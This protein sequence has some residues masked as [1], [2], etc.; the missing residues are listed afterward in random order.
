MLWLHPDG[1]VIFFSAMVLYFLW[2]DGHQLGKNFYWAAVFCGVLTSTKLVGL[3][4][5]LAVLLCLIWYLNKNQGNWKQ[6]FKAGSLFIGLMLLC[7]LFANAFLFSKYGRIQYFY[8][9]QGQT[10]WLSEGYGVI[11]AKGLKAAL[12][13]LRQDYGSA[14]FIAL[15][16]ALT[17]FGI[18]QEHGRFK[19]ALILAWVLPL[20]I[21][22]F[23]FTHFKY[24]YW[25]PVALP[26]FSN[27]SLLLPEKMNFSRVKNAIPLVV[28]IGLIGLVLIQVFM[29]LKTDISII[30]TRFTALKENAAI[31]FY[32]ESMRRLDRLKETPQ[33]VY[34]DYR[35][36]FPSEKKWSA[37][38]NYEIIKLCLY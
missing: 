20:S 16:F 26:L 32:N 35:L 33:N 31:A 36:Y 19:S 4:F 34:Y 7:F 15:A 30:Q 27:Y 24:Q 14:A 3:Y 13:T 8:T 29:F 2:K 25:L 22:V 28:R 37:G 5:F 9:L 6:V 12:P 17:G 23:F 21:S 18:W 10:S 38:T 1:L 11:Y